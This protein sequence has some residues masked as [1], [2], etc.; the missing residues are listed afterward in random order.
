M[1]ATIKGAFNSQRTTYAT[2]PL[3]LSQKQTVSGYLVGAKAEQSL[4]S[5]D[6]T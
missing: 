4:S 1:P 6:Y 5:K 3:H 2:A